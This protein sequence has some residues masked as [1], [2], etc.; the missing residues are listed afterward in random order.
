MD[1]ILIVVT[2]LSL[3]VAALMSIVAW[4]AV[5][6]ERRRSEARVTALA[7]DIHILDDFQG[8]D[9]APAGAST[10]APENDLPLQAVPTSISTRS[11][12]APDHPT[13]TR[14]RLAVVVALGVLGVGASAALAVALGGAGRSNGVEPRSDAA[15]QAPAGENATPDSAT[16]T[17]APLELVALG[18]E[19]DGDSLTVRGVLRNPAGGE[20]LGQLTAVVLLFNQDGGFVASGRAAVQAPRLEPGRETTFVITV[21]DVADVERFRVSFRTEDRMVPH[22]DL[23]G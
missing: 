17:T 4:R 7:A 2:L 20:E 12:F 6:S 14:S 21:P 19:R 15:Q 5:R 18:H 10:R 13:P 11:M 9:T 3:T 1:L 23:R 22:V 8:R 16:V